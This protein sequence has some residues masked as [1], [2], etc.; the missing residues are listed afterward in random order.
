MRRYY[1]LFNLENLIL[2][3][4]YF[5]TEKKATWDTEEDISA[6]YIKLINII[7]AFTNLQ[8]D[9]FYLLYMKLLQEKKIQIQNC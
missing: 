4:L 7:N 9:F 2:E 8:I 5:T 1:F 3:K 6:I